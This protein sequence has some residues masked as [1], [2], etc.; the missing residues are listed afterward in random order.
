[1][2]LRALQLGCSMSSIVEMIYMLC[3]ILR[4]MLGPTVELLK[5]KRGSKADNLAVGNGAQAAGYQLAFYICIELY[6]FVFILLQDGLISHNCD[7]I[8]E[9]LSSFVKQFYSSQREYLS[10]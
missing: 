8:Q 6:E 10:R 5:G 9:A 3:T 7:T 4:V 1:M 2:A